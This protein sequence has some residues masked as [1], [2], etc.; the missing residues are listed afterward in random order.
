MVLT[1]ALK[2]RQTTPRQ[3]LS[4]FQGSRTA[5]F[6]GVTPA[7]SPSGL[8]SLLRQSFRNLGNHK[9]QRLKF[10]AHRLMRRIRAW[11]AVTMLSITGFAVPPVG[12][13]SDSVQWFTA[14]CPYKEPYLE[15][16]IKSINNLPKGIREPLA[17]DFLG[18]CRRGMAE[19]SA[20]NT[21]LNSFF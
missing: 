4:S 10:K 11:S 15:L 1:T 5:G 21:Y 13:I 16:E 19:E 18:H 20:Y 6:P 12:E 8:R 3:N 2:G 17:I 14:Q 7:C 9:A